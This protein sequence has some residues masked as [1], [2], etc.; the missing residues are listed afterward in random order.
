MIRNA[1]FIKLR[2]VQTL[3]GW[4]GCYGANVW[5]L[6]WAVIYMNII[7]I[8]RARANPKIIEMFWCVWNDIEFYNK[9]WYDNV[10]ELA[11]RWMFLKINLICSRKTNGLTL[12]LKDTSNFST[13]HFCSPYGLGLCDASL[14]FLRYSYFF[15]YDICIFKSAKTAVPLRQ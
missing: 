13:K 9:K 11:K 1:Y 12:L 2:F 8:H 14:I 7:D 4:R 5:V 10:L 15:K 3:V 6:I